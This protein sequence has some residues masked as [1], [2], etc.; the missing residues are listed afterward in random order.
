MRD[1]HPHQNVVLDDKDRFL[2]R[3]CHHR[4]MAPSMGRFLTRSK[5]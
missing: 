3:L 4:T 5:T 1:R 2:N